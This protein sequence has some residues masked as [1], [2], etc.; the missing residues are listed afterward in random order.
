M[1]VRGWLV[2]F[3]V[4]FLIVSFFFIILQIDRINVG[5]VSINSVLAKLD[6]ASQQT[7]AD[8]KKVAGDLTALQTSLEQVRKDIVAVQG[9]LSSLETANQVGNVKETLDNVQTEVSALHQNFDNLEVVIQAISQRLDNL[10][11]ESGQPSSQ[12]VAGGSCAI[13]LD[14]SNAPQYTGQGIE[15]YFKGP[16]ISAQYD[17]NANNALTLLNIGSDGENR[18]LAWITPENRSKFSSAPEQLFVGKN[19]CVHGKVSSLQ[20]PA[21]AMIPAIEIQSPDQIMVVD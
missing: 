16:A 5:M 2:G 3:F 18:L 21:G 14:W 12:R 19:V 8:P 9:R 1:N 4:V 11:K 15:E 17:P 7:M 6:A 10:L 13:A 20:D